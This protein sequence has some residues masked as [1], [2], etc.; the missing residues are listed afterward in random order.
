MNRYPP[1]AL[2]TSPA[3]R[4]LARSLSLAG[5]LCL[6]AGAALLP[7]CEPLERYT[8]STVRTATVTLSAED[9][10]VVES[11]FPLLV[12]GMRRRDDLS[13][14]LQAEVTTSSTTTSKKIA[15]ELAVDM[16]RV[17]AR[18]VKLKVTAPADAVLGGVFRVWIPADLQLALFS[19]GGPVEV[20]R[21]EGAM[22]INAITH[23]RVVGAR[24]HVT[25]R[26]ESGNALVETSQAPGVITDVLVGRGDVQVTL[27]A[28]LSAQIAATAG[29]GGAVLASHPS[30]PAMQ[31]G[32]PY[33]VSVN[34]GLSQL[35]AETRLGNV[36]LRSP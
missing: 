16:E 10:L 34:G 33:R 35:R 22:V 27:P 13:Y 3:Q 32:R 9:T 18:T 20:D 15:D 17:D 7:A 19:Q 23:A 1:E 2:P 29:G 12:T 5:A 14:H 30:L 6:L 4:R 8:E 25:L 21:V 24:N 11:A 26:V 28:F 36:I 31:A